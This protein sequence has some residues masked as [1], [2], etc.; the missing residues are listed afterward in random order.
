MRSF[1]LYFIEKKTLSGYRYLEHGTHY[2]ILAL[3]FTIFVKMFTQ[4]NQTI[5][6]ELRSHLSLLPLIVLL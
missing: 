4:I 5:L 1:T 2:A 6:E 3:A